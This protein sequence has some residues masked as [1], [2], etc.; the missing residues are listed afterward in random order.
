MYE[1]HTRTNTKDD[2]KRKLPDVGHDCNVALLDWY[3]RN[4]TSAGVVVA[5]ARCLN[6]TTV[7]LCSLFL[8]SESDT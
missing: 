6:F 1:L 7:Y 5:A 4:K 3:W 8:G 2:K